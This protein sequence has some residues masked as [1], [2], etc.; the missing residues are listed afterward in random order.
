MAYYEYKTVPAP[1]ILTI[2]NDKE[3]RIAIANF[4]EAINQVARDGWEFVSMETIR[5]KEA[6]GCFSTG[7]ETE[8]I[9]NMLVFKRE[10]GIK[11]ENMEEA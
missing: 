4:G 6:E 5:T 1:M 7:K 10:I 3:E 2:K 11:A 8:K 9:H